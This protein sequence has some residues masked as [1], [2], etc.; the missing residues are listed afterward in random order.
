MECPKGSSCKESEHIVKTMKMAL[1]WL[2][3]ATKDMLPIRVNQLTAENGRV[4]IS[5]WDKNGVL[6]H[7]RG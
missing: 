6:I 2:P 1:E 5:I 3:R 7:M 4:Q